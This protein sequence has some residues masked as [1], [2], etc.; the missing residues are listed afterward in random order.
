MSHQILVQIAIVAVF[1]GSLEKL[2]I[3]HSGMILIH[4]YL[5]LN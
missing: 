5:T 3:I 2:I 1:Q 4:F